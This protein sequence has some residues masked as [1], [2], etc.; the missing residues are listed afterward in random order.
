[1]IF[2]T[3][4]LHESCLSVCSS[5]FIWW[6]LLFS[7]CVCLLL[8]FAAT[9]TCF[10]LGSCIPIPKPTCHST[11]LSI[12]VF[13][14]P[15]DCIP[16]HSGT[17]LPTNKPTHSLTITVHTHFWHAFLLKKWSIQVLKVFGL[18]NRFVSGFWFFIQT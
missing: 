2:V 1:M 17:S 6:W 14:I 11:Y 9:F 4:H 13:F 5:C 16:V 10:Q 7:F 12:F 18:G 3:L 15:A 8:F